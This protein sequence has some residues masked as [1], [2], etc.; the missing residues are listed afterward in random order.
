MLTMVAPNFFEAFPKQFKP[1]L[2]SGILLTTI[3]TV[4]LNAFF[5]GAGS[6]ETKKAEAH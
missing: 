4:A 2:E 6:T 1:L 3:V 5:N